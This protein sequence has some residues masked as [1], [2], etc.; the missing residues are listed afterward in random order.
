MTGALEAV[1]RL[2][3]GAFALDLALDVP[4]GGVL[5]LMGRNGAGKS[6]AVA[7][8]AGL[9]PLDAGRVVQRGT[10]ATSA[11][12]CMASTIRPMES[13]S[14]PSQSKISS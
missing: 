3:R 8:V 11:A 14:V 5:A 12:R 13:T 1:L 2:D 9:V 10:H 4:A 7:A 6:T